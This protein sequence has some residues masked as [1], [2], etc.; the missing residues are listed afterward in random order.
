[1]DMSIL[2]YD[3]KHVRDEA[4][5]RHMYEQWLVK[6]RKN[7]NALGEKELRFEIFKDN[8][9]FIDDHNAKNAGTSSFRLGL[10]RFADLTNLEY[11]SMYLGAKL[12][13]SAGMPSRQNKASRYAFRAGD[14]LPE[15][16]DW[17]AKGAVGPVK[18]QGQ[19]G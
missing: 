3:A 8:L 7:Y 15:T 4:H 5:V 11:R 2:D 14:D 1:M 9:R 12:N 13:R 19:C 16:V 10:T 18:D 17:R 6:H